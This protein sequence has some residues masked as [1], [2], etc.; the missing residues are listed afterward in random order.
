[1]RYLGIDFGLKKIGM[2]LGDDETKIASP[3]ETIANTDQLM[4]KLKELVK[5]EGI[6]EVVVGVP[7]SAGT[8]HTGEQFALTQKFIETLRSEIDLPVHEEDERYTSVESQRL[9]K[10]YGAQA[11][12]DSLAAMLILQQFLDNSFPL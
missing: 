8:F 7:M 12:E 5:Q 4:N 2:A 6:E 3:I 10:E 11:S 1:M 9:Q